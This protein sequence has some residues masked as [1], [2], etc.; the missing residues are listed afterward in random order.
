MDGDDCDCLRTIGDDL[1]LPAAKSLPIRPLEA[2]RSSA[3]LTAGDTKKVSRSPSGK[4]KQSADRRG[5][6]Q[7]G[8]ERELGR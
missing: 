5:L 7:I 8:R 6:E 4:S 2:A 3:T 1:S